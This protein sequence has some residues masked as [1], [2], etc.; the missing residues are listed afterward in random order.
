LWVLVTQN[1]ECKGIGNLGDMSLAKLV[2][3]LDF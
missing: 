1:Y 3:T 2:L